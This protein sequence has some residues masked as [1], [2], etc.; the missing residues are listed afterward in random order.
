MQ[1]HPQQMTADGVGQ[2]DECSR[3]RQTRA[4]PCQVRLVGVVHR[5]DAL[6]STY[7]HGQRCAT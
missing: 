6:T 7:V 4:E 1:T 5:A 3:V 2:H